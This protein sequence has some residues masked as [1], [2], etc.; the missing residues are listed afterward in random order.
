M[1]Q[2]KMILLALLFVAPSAHAFRDAKVHLEIQALKG[3]LIKEQSL[4][5]RI[6]LV[7]KFKSFIDHYLQNVVIENSDRGREEFASLNEFEMALF[8]IKVN[9]KN[10]ATTCRSSSAQIRS[11]GT[12][13]EEKNTLAPSATQTLE[14]LSLLC[15]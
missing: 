6:V 7:E 10:P 13:P 11:E 2:L 1:S 4:Q 3:S 14:I 8:T 5:Q 9:E 15:R 12:L